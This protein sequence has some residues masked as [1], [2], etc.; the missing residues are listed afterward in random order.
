MT[1]ETLD[2][3]STLNISRSAWEIHGKDTDTIGANMAE[4]AIGCVSNM[5][6]KNPRIIVNG[7]VPYLGSR[8]NVFWP[9]LIAL[10]ACIAGVYFALFASAIYT[11]RL[12]VIKDDSNLSTARLPRP[13]AEDLGHSGTVL[14]G[15]EL[16]QVITRGEGKGGIVYG[17]RNVEGSTDYYLDIGNSVP[18][19]TQWKD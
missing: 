18:P 11:S 16:S 14:K 1:V 15:K 2:A 6:W 5:A 7:S 19:R 3:Y 8:T 10:L 12:V 13:M 4:F 17:P 9:Y